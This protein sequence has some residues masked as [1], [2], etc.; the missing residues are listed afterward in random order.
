MVFHEFIA[1]KKIDFSA[2]RVSFTGFRLVIVAQL[3]RRLVVAR[4]PRS[5]Q[6]RLSPHFYSKSIFPDPDRFWNA[7]EAFLWSKTVP[8]M[9]SSFKA[10]ICVRDTHPVKVQAIRKKVKNACILHTLSGRREKVLVDR[11]SRLHFAI[12]M[13]S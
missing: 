4:R 12:N 10:S 8:L 5:F 1:S 2:K 6:I 11:L 13:P 7:H 9:I 3:V